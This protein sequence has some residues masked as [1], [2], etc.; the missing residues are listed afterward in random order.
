MMSTNNE[1]DLQ[2]K[3]ERLDSFTRLIASAIRASKGHARASNIAGH[4]RILP[5]SIQ[6]DRLNLRAGGRTA[7]PYVPGM[8]SDGPEPCYNQVLTGGR[9]GH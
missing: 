5:G 3:D 9:H 1:F 2:S 6:P 8:R 4:K 7:S